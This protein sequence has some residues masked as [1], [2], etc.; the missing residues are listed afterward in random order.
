[1]A[2]PKEPFYSQRFTAAR[3]GIEWRLTYEQWLSIWTKS[4]KLSQRGRRSHEF[5]MARKGDSGPYAV[6][7]VRI[8][9]NWQNHHER[10][11]SAVAD[12]NRRRMRDPKWVKKVRALGHARAKENNTNPALIA[13]RLAGIQRYWRERGF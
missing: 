8:V 4:G 1:V 9:T 7:N 3:R 10:D 13:S 2:H 6:G 5:C 11:V 12:A